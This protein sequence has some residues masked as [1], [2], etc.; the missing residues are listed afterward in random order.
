[1]VNKCKSF[2]Y[3]FDLIGPSPKLFIFHGNSNKTKFGGIL[4]FIFMIGM[5]FIS[6]AYI[7]WISNKIGLNF[8]I[9]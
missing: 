7:I 8:F 9:I 3:I 2:L 1:M 6:L 4:S 5:L